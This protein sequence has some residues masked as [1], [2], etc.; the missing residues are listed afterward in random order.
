MSNCTDLYSEQQK[1]QSQIEKQ[2]NEIA[3][4]K[5]DALEKVSML[6]TVQLLSPGNL[7]STRYAWNN[8]KIHFSCRADTLLAVLLVHKPYRD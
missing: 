4:Q 2:K 7:K 5:R 8:Q 3:D 6:C 1:L